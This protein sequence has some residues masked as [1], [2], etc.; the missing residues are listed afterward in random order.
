MRSKEVWMDCQ[1]HDRRQGEGHSLRKDIAQRQY[2]RRMV[3]L[4]LVL[5]RR[6]QLSLKVLVFKGRWL[7]RGQWYMC[8]QA[9]CVDVSMWRRSVELSFLGKWPSPSVR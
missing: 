8:P 3:S 5:W 1:K 4:S 2:G 9:L 6:A 7:Q